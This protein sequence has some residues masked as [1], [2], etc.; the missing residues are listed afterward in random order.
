MARRLYA[1]TIGGSGSSTS[2]ATALDID[3]AGAVYVAGTTTASDFPVSA[4]AVQ[5]PGAT[6]FAAKLD[7]KGNILYSA[8]IGG[9]ATHEPSSIVVNSKGELVVSG[10]LTTGARFVSGSRALPAEAERGRDPGR[11]RTAKV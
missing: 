9:N 8:L 5:S 3:S 6:A 7:A 10:Q 2:A 4:G 1:A 11:H